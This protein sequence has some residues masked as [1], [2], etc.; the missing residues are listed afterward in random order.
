MQNVRIFT[1][2]FDVILNFKVLFMRKYLII[3][4]SFALLF[5]SCTKRTYISEEVVY[6]VDGN[7]ES[8]IDNS[9]KP[10]KTNVSVRDEQEL[11][12]SVIEYAHSLEG[13][14]YKWGGTTPA[15]FDCSGFVQHVYAHFGVKIPRMPA[16]MAAIS[17]K[18]DLKNVKPGDLVYFKGSNISSGEIGHVALVI[19]SSGD[20]FKMIHATSKGVVVNSFSQYDYWKIRYLFATRFAKSLL[21]NN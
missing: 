12:S 3:V 18:V 10:D 7:T 19:S 13:T 5:F 9:S 15:G 1:S 11:I 16:D 14:P 8:G 4:F 2:S 6:S 17:T 21:I 20:D